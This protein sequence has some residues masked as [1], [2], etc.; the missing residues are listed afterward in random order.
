MC[1]QGFMMGPGV[2]RNLTSLIVNGR[3]ALP[4]EVHA[5]FSYQRDFHAAR[6]EAL[7]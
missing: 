3:P 1:G 2:A 6:K 4:P 7:K 5:C